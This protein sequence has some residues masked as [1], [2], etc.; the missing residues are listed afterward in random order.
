METRKIAILGFGALLTGAVAVNML[1]NPCGGITRR[2]NGN[3]IVYTDKR[4]D[5]YG[6]GTTYYFIDETSNGPGIDKYQI[7]IKGA[8]TSPEFSIFDAS[9]GIKWVAVNI[10]KDYAEQ[11]A[12]KGE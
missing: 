12:K 8:E 9:T 1:V 3:E 6:S 4:C 7:G 11:E 5:R 10:E 2:K